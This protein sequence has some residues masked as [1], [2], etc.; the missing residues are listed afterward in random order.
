M[1]Q[2]PPGKRFKSAMWYVLTVTKKELTYGR[3]YNMSTSIR[4]PLSEK[5]ELKE[6]IDGIYYVDDFISDDELEQLWGIIDN[7]DATDW[8]RDYVENLEETAMHVCGTKDYRSCVAKGLMFMNEN[9]IDKSLQ[10]PGD[11]PSI[12]S[13]RIK[14]FFP[15]NISIDP[16]RTIQRHYPG[17]MLDEHVDAENDPKLAYAAVIY[18]NDDFNGGDLY[19]PIKELKIRPK[20]KRLV[21]FDTSSD[22][23]HG[24]KMVEPGPTRY[25]MA[26]FIYEIDV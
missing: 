2:K 14:D 16:L 25:A 15:D 18:L 24:V 23:L 9:W 21:L 7:A 6:I 19:F 12:F 17:S 5:Y 4:K 20:K 3:F 8:G 11:I 26:G 13:N 1:A 22:F 10:V